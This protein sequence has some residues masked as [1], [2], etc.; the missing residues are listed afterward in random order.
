MPRHVPA[1]QQKMD[2]INSLNGS[3][4]LDNPSSFFLSDI[5]YID[6]RHII[7]LSPLRPT[8]SQQCTKCCE[9]MAGCQVFFKQWHEGGAGIACLAA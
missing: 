5:A 4:P 7:H 3:V 8:R 1:K 2:D 9:I 6:L